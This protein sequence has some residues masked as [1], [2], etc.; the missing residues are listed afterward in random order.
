MRVTSFTIA[1]LLLA[2]LAV[3]LLRSGAFSRIWKAAAG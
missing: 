2:I 1:G 3:R